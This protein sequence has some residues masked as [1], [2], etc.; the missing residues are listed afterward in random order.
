MAH[1]DVNARQGDRATMAYSLGIAAGLWTLNVRLE[2]VCQTWGDTARECSGTLG[3]TLQSMKSCK[4][5][6][7]QGLTALALQLGAG[8]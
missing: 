6:V 3:G 4:V 7:E 8:H 2:M 1:H 5:A